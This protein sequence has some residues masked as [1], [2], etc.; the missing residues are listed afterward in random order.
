MST[1]LASF[2][3]SVSAAQPAVGNA[4]ASQPDYSKQW[5]E[6]LKQTAAAAAAVQPTGA[7]AQQV[8]AAPSAATPAA[9][10][11]QP[12]TTQVHIHT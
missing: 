12:A 11:A 10:T 8:A 1:N 2:S 9:A 5:D 3:I 7:I 4:V 6:Y